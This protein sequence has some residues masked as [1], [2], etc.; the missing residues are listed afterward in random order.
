MKDWK[1]RRREKSG[2]CSKWSIR[3][4]GQ[5]VRLRLVVRT[6]QHWNAQLNSEH[7]GE[8][9]VIRLHTAKVTAKQVQGAIVRGVFTLL[10]IVFLTPLQDGTENP[11]TRLPH[12]DRY[13]KILEARK[14]LPVY[15]QMDDFYKMYAKHQIII[16]VGETG[17]GKTTQI[18]QFVVYSDMP[19]TK[20]KI[21]A[22]TQPRRLTTMSAAKRVA[23]EMDV[24]LGKQVGYSIR[25]ED[26]T[27]PGTTILK[28][29]TDGLLFREL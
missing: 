8:T 7:N 1:A 6:A 4:G 20:R 22:C 26:M 5:A 2:G 21:V 14:K 19:Q 16:V 15:T 11:F 12:S 9:S 3:T 13:H 24:L 10:Y 25:F 27:E 17:S 23:D 28:Y 18:P 29:M